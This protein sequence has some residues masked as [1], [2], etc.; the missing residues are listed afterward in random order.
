MRARPKSSRG[1]THGVVC[2]PD[3]RYAFVTSEGRNAEPGALD[4][5]DLRTNRVVASCDVGLQAG[6]IA[7]LD[8]RDR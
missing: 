8:Q 2:S 6:G 4:V 3:G 5:V 7:F 1:V